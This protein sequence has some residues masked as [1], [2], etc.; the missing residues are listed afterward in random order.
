MDKRL[1]Q[2][3]TR[4]RNATQGSDQP[5]LSAAQAHNLAALTASDC[6]MAQLA[7]DLCAGQAAIL[8]RAGGDDAATAKLALQP[9]INLGRL[10]IRDGDESGH[11]HFE[12]LFTAAKSRTDTVIAGIPISFSE[13]TATQ[14]DHRTIVQWLWSILLSDGTRALTQTGRWSQ[15]LQH[16]QRHNAIGR[17]L[18]DGR[19]TAVLAHSACGDPDYALQLLD[20][21]H[22]ESPWEHTVAATLRVL[23]RSR[24]GRDRP[25]DIEEIVERYPQAEKTVREHSAFRVR[26]GLCVIDLAMG[27]PGTHHIT[28]AVVHDA[29][30]AEDASLAH[31]VLT[32]R[33]C[34]A[35][36][37]PSTA[38]TLQERIDASGLGQ[39]TLPA[40]A[41]RD[42]MES[43]RTSE[44]ALKNALNPS[45]RTDASTG[46]GVAP[47]T[48]TEAPRERP[49]GINEHPHRHGVA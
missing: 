17:R 38:A 9:L 1:D 6:G 8:L 20:S 44:K 26:Q 14:E 15:A 11:H 33:T 2:I 12:R 34:R 16:I 48:G 45:S 10:L 37:A 21:S 46:Q 18:L 30:E 32:H 41:R 43:V 4:A 47:D 28:E 3:R 5:L 25:P 29:L 39:G 7:R 23:C 22:T 42:L 19:Q 31:D 40:E 49:E 13:L 36:L 27:L 35:R 24:A